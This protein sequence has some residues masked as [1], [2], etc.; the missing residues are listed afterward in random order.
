M[1]LRRPPVKWMRGLAAQKRARP[2][3]PRSKK[4]SDR[5]RL[6]AD[7]RRLAREYRANNLYASAARRIHRRDHVL[8]NH[9]RTGFDENN[10]LRAILVNVIQLLLKLSLRHLQS[11]DLVNA[12]RLD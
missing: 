3:G 11:V 6:H 4:C 12:I 8:V 1:A 5:W 7:L 2:G 9:V 10:L